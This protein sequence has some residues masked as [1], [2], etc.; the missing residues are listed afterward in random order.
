MIFQEK[1]LQVSSNVEILSTIQSISG[2]LLIAD[3]AVYASHL[4]KVGMFL[5]A[6]IRIFRSISEMI[7]LLFT[8]G[9]TYALYRHI[10]DGPETEQWSSLGGACHYVAL[11][12]LTRTSSYCSLKHGCIAQDS[13]VQ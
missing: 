6:A 7:L 12:W 8:L 2:F 13:H 10:S 5:A 1:L 11:G 3:L 9:V 4:P